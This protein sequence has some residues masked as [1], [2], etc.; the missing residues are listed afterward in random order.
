MPD[1]FI[2]YSRDDREWVS[3]FAAALHEARGWNVWWD[4]NLL[5]GDQ[6]DEVIQTTLDQSKAAVVV[7]S[8]V[9]VESRWVKSEAREAVRRGVLVPVLIGDVRLP[10]EFSSFEA[11]DLRQWDGRADHDDFSELADALARVISGEARAETVTSVPRQAP[12]LAPSPVPA[13]RSKVVKIAA[14]AAGVL[15]VLLLIS[16]GLA[17][18][19]ESADSS[20]PA[21]PDFLVGTWTLHNATDAGGNDWSNSV[22]KFTSQE[23][24]RDGQALRG[25]FTWRLDAQPMWTEEV[26]GHYI[27]RTRQVILEGESVTDL[28]NSAEKG[29]PGSYS[30]RLADDER[31][32]V[33]GRWGSVGSAPAV[34]PGSWEATR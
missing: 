23:P 17:D 1:I 21:M 14:A 25:T 10:I 6:Y 7:W 31:T 28:G 33:E 5:P 4:R 32:L 30:A 34:N 12:R 22:L 15:I 27:A 24:D 8:P 19:P 3:R 9:S 29:A 11:A 13:R 26:S 2:S 18:S 16:L 20:P